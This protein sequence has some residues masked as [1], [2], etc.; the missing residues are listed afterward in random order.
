L[1]IMAFLQ[2][3]QRKVPFVCCLLWLVSTSAYPSEL[4]VEPQIGLARLSGVRVYYQSAG[5]AENALVFVHGWLC[6]SDFWKLN[7]A[8]FHENRTIAVDLP[9]HGRSDK[10]RISY[11]SEYFARSIE[12]VL[13]DA[14]VEQAV[15]VGH[16]MGV[17]VIREFYRLYPQRTLGLVIVDGALQLEAAADPEKILAPF[18]ADYR[19]A[20]SSAVESMTQPIRD[21]GLKDEVRSIML[22]TPDYVGKSAMENVFDQKIWGR[23]RMDVPVLAILAESSHWKP[24][25]E[26]SF[27][28]IAPQLEFHMWWNVSHFLMLD[29]PTEFNAA[30]RDFVFRN[31]LLES[32]AAASGDR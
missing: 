10:P 29:R 22:R 6:S 4:R 1:L 27:R 24:D 18:R 30:V 26:A 25:A 19:R 14:G 15:L 28:E 11:T 16:S 20:V 5:N 23:D 32:Q 21:E 8:S 13:R 9:G 12:A 2:T 3:R 17:P 31:R 7:L